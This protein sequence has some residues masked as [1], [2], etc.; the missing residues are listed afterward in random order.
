MLV[1]FE[2]FRV[3]DE[4]KKN[5]FFVEVNFSRNP[6]IDK[7]KVLRITFPGGEKAYIKKEHLM[8]ILFAIG[9]EE[10]QRKMIPTRVQRVKWYETVVSVIAKKDI[11][12]GER[13][14][15]PIKLSLPGPEEEVIQDIRSRIKKRGV[16]SVI[17]Q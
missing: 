4:N 3:A 15:F 9:K 7:C 13:I 10:E 16:D 1:G 12:R 17:N 11:Q 8:A 14:V 6:K 5:D 2:K